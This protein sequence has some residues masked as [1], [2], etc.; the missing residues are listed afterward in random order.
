VNSV[1]II[2][3]GLSRN[4][5]A[6]YVGVGGTLFDEL[7]KER[8]MPRPSWHIHRRVLWDRKK[9]DQALDALDEAG[10]MLPPSEPDGWEDL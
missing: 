10:T 2:P 6:A 8:K 3:R 5:A 7:V 9:L 4:E 1:T